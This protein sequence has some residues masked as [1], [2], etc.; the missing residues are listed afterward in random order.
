MFHYIFKNMKVRNNLIRFLNSG[1]FLS[2]M[3]IVLAFV[4]LIFIYTRLALWMHS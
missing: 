2:F 4:L 1:S 3:V